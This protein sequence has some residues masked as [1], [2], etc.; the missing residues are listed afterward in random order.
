MDH[1][2]LHALDGATGRTKWEFTTKES[3]SSITLA[4]DGALILTESRGTIHS[5]VY[6]EKKLAEKRKKEEISDQP[7][8]VESDGQY[9]IIDDVKIPI[10]N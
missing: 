3:P 7:S 9:I 1:R 10:R 2:G 8:Q 5:I 4:P 6:D